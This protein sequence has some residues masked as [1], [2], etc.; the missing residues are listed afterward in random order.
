[1]VVQIFLIGLG[2]SADAFA[3]SVT[4]GLTNKNIS[5]KEALK[6]AAAFGIFQALMP[7]LGFLLGTFFEEFIVKLDH[8][9]ALI[10]LGFIGGKMLIDGIT[11]KGKAD[12]TEKTDCLP[13]RTLI[14]QAI[15]TSIDAL[16]AGVVFIS[17][18]IRGAWILPAVALIGVITFVISFA[19]VRLGR[20]FGALLGG[21]AKIV[22]GIILIGIG[23]KVFLEHVFFS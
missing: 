19:G 14:I 23:L 16:V 12:F 4:N 5:R 7:F 20:K 17:M 15:A 1:M 2:L 10:F 3:V 22:G 9:V 18:G 6:I 11:D 8:Y 13:V 21:K